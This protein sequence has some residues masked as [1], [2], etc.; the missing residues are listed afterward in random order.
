MITLYAMMSEFY[1][2][3]NWIFVA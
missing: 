1:K 3:Y 2:M